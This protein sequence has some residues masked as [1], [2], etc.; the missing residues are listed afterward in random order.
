MLSV[1]HI[2]RYDLASDL[3]L[4]LCL[5]GLDVVARLLPH[6]PN[7]SPLA[8]SAVFAAMVF[9]NSPLAVA[10][11]VAAM[12]LS[13]LFLGA[14]D[15]RI[16]SIAYLTLALAAMVARWGRKFRMPIVLVP[17]VL[18]SS[19]LFFV[20]T[21]FAVWAFSGMYPNTVAGL[22]Q[23]FVLALPFLHN[24]IAGDV[25]WATVLFGGSY[26]IKHAIDAQRLS[27]GAA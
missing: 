5:V 21:N 25:F 13:D 18:S 10:T 14:D 3:L 19:L 26:L 11:P 15:W 8:A 16:A 7:F 23:C 1:S 12:L 4:A 2:R 22:V 17:L 24:S 27:P 20:T 6:A 9:R